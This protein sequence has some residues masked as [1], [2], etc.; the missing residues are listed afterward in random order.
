MGLFQ[1]HSTCQTSPRKC[2]PKAPRDW[3][4]RSIQ[5]GYSLP[6]SPPSQ[7]LCLW[8]VLD[9]QGWG[10]VSGKTRTNGPME[11]LQVPLHL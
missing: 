9:H 2:V 6:K 11:G 8:Q 5:Q 1:G 10:D 3:K 7:A 4:E